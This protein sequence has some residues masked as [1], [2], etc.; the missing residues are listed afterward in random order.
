MSVVKNTLKELDQWSVSMINYF[1][2]YSYNYPGRIE[3]SGS[4]GMMISSAGSTEGIGNKVIV[5]KYK[6]SSITDIREIEAEI[7]NEWM[8]K[9]FMRSI[10]YMTI[11]I[12]SWQKF[13]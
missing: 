7:E 3:N 4:M 9:D 1:V 13:E 11:Q 2:S 8:K 10:D 12:I 6:I 5:R